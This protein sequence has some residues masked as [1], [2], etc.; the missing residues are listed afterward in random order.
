MD[1]P[2]LPALNVLLNSTFDF[3]KVEWYVEDLGYEYKIVAKEGDFAGKSS[4]SK[5]AWALLAPKGRELALQ[6]EIMT[7][8]SNLID[9]VKNYQHF[10][11]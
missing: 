6:V 4:I 5:R 2:Y 10:G 11:E 7:A 9:D 8:A 1:R 3:T